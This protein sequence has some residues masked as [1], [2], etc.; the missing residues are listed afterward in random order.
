[1]NCHRLMILLL[2]STT[3]LG[4]CA[5][6]PSGGS[7]NETVINGPPPPVIKTVDVPV[8][9]HVPES[10]PPKDKPPKKRDPLKV[11]AEVN[12]RSVVIPDPDD[13][14]GATY[15]LPTIPNMLYQVYMAEGQLTTIDLPPGETYRKVSISKP[16]RWEIIDL[17]TSENDDGEQ[18]QT[19]QVRPYEGGL[20]RETLNIKTNRTTHRFKVNTYKG[21]FHHGVV[22]K[23]PAK[24]LQFDPP[25]G[26]PGVEP[27]GH[28]PRIPTDIGDYGYSIGKGKAPWR[29]SAVFTHAGK[30]FIE[31]P[32]NGGPV[33]PPQ[34]VDTSTGEDKA[35]NWYVSHKRYMVV[36]DQVLTKAEL[37][38]GETTI[39][40]ER[41]EE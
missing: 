12:S 4:A 39:K 35:V 11:L 8:F 38:R 41:I 1:M 5:A 7:I 33:Q 28:E 25:E 10:N 15:V 16:D 18:V 40:I 3:L 30:T 22:M 2:S 31:L 24:G 13:Y 34:L 37:R 9:V 32:A 23:A 21:I 29:P 20:R 14:I 26:P 6:G 27:L 36:P 17:G 19:I